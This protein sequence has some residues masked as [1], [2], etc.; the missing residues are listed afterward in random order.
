M[1]LLQQ[2]QEASS[3]SV[4]DLKKAVQKDPRAAPVLKAD[5]KLDDI[6]DK[7]AFL[8]SVKFHILNNDKVREFV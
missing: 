1:S 3:L 5:L 6:A 7:E 2:L 8:A 4:A